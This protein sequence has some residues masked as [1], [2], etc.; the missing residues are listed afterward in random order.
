MLG[1]L[2]SGT[3]P[4]NIPTMSLMPRTCLG[5]A[6][7][8]RSAPGQKRRT[9]EFD[10][11]IFLHGLLKCQAS[12][13]VS[14]KTTTHIYFPDFRRVIPSVARCFSSTLDTHISSPSRLVPWYGCRLCA[15]QDASSHLRDASSHLRHDPRP[16]QRLEHKPG[17][18]ATH[19]P[20][21]RTNT[22]RDRG[23][24]ASSKLAAGTR[25]SDWLRDAKL[26]PRRPIPALAQRQSFQ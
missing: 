20:R 19:H 9:E 17:E 24:P 6:R 25:W 8:P 3:T 11:A 7:P 4:G 12:E 5:G 16:P 22:P 1:V 26:A 10:T 23:V 15:R 21:Q 2:K 13:L 18:G 14:H